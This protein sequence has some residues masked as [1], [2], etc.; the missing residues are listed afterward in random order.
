M[1]IRT[2]LETGNFD[3]YTVRNWL[4]H[5]EINTT[6]EYIRY[7]EQFYRIAGYD[8]IKA[9]L[10]TRTGEK[11]SFYETTVD[12][13]GFGQKPSLWWI[14]VY[15]IPYRL[16]GEI[17]IETCWENKGFDNP[18]ASTIFKPF[19]S[20]FYISVDVDQKTF[21]IFFCFSQTSSTPHFLPTWSTSTIPP[22]TTGGETM[23]ILFCP[24]CGS[25]RVRHRLG[26]KKARCRNCGKYFFPKRMGCKWRKNNN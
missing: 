15:R 7:A 8:W 21:F 14:R 10:K 4:G 12:K 25:N 1:L 13:N 24:E 18:L 2:K 17:L 20:F 5:E 23:L 11:G 3:V 19:F 16:Y 9:T 22:P 26:S 6:M